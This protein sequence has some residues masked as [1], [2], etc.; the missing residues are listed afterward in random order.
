MLYLALIVMINVKQMHEMIVISGT[1]KIVFSKNIMQQMR[2]FFNIN[3]NI[4]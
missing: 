3:I 2:A 4:L 1:K